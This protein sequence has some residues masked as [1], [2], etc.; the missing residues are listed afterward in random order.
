MT[1]TEED[2][3]RRYKRCCYLFAL[4]LLPVQA[5]KEWV[6]YQLCNCLQSFSLIRVEQLRERGEGHSGHALLRVE[7]LRERGEG[8]SG[9]ALL[10]VEQLRERGEGHSG[11]ALLR[12][13]QLRERGEGH[14]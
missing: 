13:E 4:D 12:V 2:T 8:H 10:R 1:K 3:H 14:S 9:H 5:L 11:H 7:Q 6:W